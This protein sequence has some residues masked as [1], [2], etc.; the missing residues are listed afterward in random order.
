MLSRQGR[1]VN[2]CFGGGAPKM[3]FKEEKKETAR[4]LFKSLL[5]SIYER[6]LTVFYNDM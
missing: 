2:L 6:L 5:R 4:G 1:E 3:D